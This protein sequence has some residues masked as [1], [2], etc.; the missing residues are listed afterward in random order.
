[1]TSKVGRGHLG[2]ILE[3]IEPADTARVDLWRA[4]RS[5]ASQ[6]TCSATPARPRSALYDV[7]INRRRV[8]LNLDEDVVEALKSF[9]GRSLSAAANDALR[10]AVAVQARRATLTRWLNLQ[11]HYDLDGLHGRATPSQAASIDA[12][13]DEQAQY[14]S[15]IGVATCAALR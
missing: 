11:S 10:Q 4:G 13:V 7:C 3:T 8:T 14:C 5:A 12:L 15:D 6:T 1:M 2:P 9:G